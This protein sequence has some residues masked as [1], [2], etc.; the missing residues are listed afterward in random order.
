MQLELQFSISSSATLRMFTPCDHVQPYYSGSYD[1]E[2]ELDYN[3][4][5]GAWRGVSD[6]ISTSLHY[7]ISQAFT[8]SVCHVYTRDNAAR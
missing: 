2:P 1:W 3:P 6:H 4:S 7:H 8:L 5:R